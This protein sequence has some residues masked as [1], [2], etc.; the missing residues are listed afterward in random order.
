MPTPSRQFTP[1]PQPK[2]K[3]A[4]QAKA[5]ALAQ[6]KALQV[7][8]ERRDQRRQ[9]CKTL[10]ELAQELHIAPTNHVDAKNAA[11]PDVEDLVRLL[12][13]RVQTEAHVTMLRTTVEK[14]LASGG[15]FSA[16]LLDP[17][18]V[19]PAK[20]SGHRLLRPNFALKSKAFM[21]TYN[22]YHFTP[23]TWEA[24]L[25]FQKELRQKLGARAWSA[26]LEQSLHADVA[27]SQSSSKHH[28]HGYLLWTDG[29]GVHTEN[30]DVFVFQ[31]VR[32]RIDV[33]VTKCSPSSPHS[34]AAHG[35]WRFAALFRGG[36][37]TW[38]S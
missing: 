10:N 23:E 1:R 36:S 15:L 11:A 4:A 16:P 27:N 25:P 37:R 22:S 3:P 31:N 34:A 32:P 30:L 6:A 33:C 9:A 29:V 21:T 38:R 24:F 18:E 26:C 5:K 12:E 2:A 28:L 35:L 20:V 13:K 8:N 17:D 19:L 7:K 14:Y